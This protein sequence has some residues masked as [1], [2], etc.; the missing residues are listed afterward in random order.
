MRLWLFLYPALVIASL[1]SGSVHAETAGQSTDLVGSWQLTTVIVD[2][3]RNSKI[4]DDERKDPMPGGQD[5]LKLNADGTCEF[6]VH[7]TPGRYEVKTESDGRQK[8][9]LFD[10]N[11]NKENRGLI[12]S[13]TK[14]ELILLNFSTRAF[15]L[16]KRQ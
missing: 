11:N 13:V 14:D 10:K 7:K 4:D 8:L 9:M 15:S 1:P 5:Y 12:Y 6:Y 2:K 3:N 16:Y